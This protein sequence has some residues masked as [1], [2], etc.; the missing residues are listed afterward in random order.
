MDKT[1]FLELPAAIYQAICQEAQRRDLSPADF[2][3]LI[4]NHYAITHN[5]LAGFDT[6]M[7]DS[8]GTAL[9]SAFAVHRSTL[10]A[11]VQD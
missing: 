10:M 4:F 3:S 2:V 5:Q 7:E 9:Q 8:F 1:N 11:L 6:T